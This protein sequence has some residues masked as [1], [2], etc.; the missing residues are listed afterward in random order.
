[1]LLD[2]SLPSEMTTSA[3]L[4]CSPVCASGTA[5][6]TVSYIAVPPLGSIRPSA[7]LS[8]CRS[9]VHPCSSTGSLLNR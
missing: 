1:M 8:S 3:F 9:F 2:V 7:R 5:A 4:R 6:A